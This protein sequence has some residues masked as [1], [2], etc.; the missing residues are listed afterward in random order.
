[1]LEKLTIDSIQKFLRGRLQ[2]EK[3]GLAA[4]L[5][6]SPQPPPSTLTYQDVQ[7]TCLKAAV[8]ILIYP[9]DRQPHL[10]FIHRT[11][12]GNHH[13]HQISFPGGGLEAEE[14]VEQAALREAREELG[15]ATEKIIIVGQLTPLYVQPSNYCIFPLVAIGRDEMDFQPSPCEVAAVIEVPLAELLDENHIRRETWFL[16]S[17]QVAVPFFQYGEHKIW[18]ATAMILSELL[19]L[20]EELKSR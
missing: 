9:K 7:D 10:V 5:R 1:M 13:Q 3:P 8:L 11:G 19:E 17:C 14:S 6:F 2:A 4:Q 18:G 15:V 16:R 12:L 20:L